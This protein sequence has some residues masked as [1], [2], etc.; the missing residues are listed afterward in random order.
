MGTVLQTQS[1]DV[2]PWGTEPADGKLFEASA[3]QPAVQIGEQPVT[4]QP[5]ARDLPSGETDEVVFTYGLAE[6]GQKS[7]TFGPDHIAVQV[8]HPGPFTEHLPLLMR[9]D[10]DLVIA[11]GSV[12]LQREDQ[13]FVI[14][15]APDAKVEI[16]RTEVRHGPFRVVRLKLTAAESLDYRLAFQTAAE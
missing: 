14:A 13:M 8:V 2:A 1:R 6:S 7:A 4:I 12:R 10:D 15:F 9:S 5:G 3:F 11:D 16:E